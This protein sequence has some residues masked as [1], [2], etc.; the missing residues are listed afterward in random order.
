M[1]DFLLILLP[2]PIMFPPMIEG[3]SSVGMG[4][5]ELA[6]VDWSAEIAGPVVAVGLGEFAGL[7]P[8]EVAGCAPGSPCG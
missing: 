3:G 8:E 5:P 7:E 2:T 1:T 6:P 4:V